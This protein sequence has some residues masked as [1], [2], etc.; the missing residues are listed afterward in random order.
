MCVSLPKNHAC[1]TCRSSSRESLLFD[2]ENLRRRITEDGAGFDDDGNEGN[3]RSV[4]LYDE[5]DD[6]QL[7]RYGDIDSDPYDDL[8]LA[9]R[10]ALVRKAVLARQEHG[11]S[12]I[13][14]GARPLKYLN[15]K[16]PLEAAV[17]VDP[18]CYG[19]S[20]A[21]VEQAAAHAEY[22]AAQAELLSPKEKFKAAAEKVIAAKKAGLSVEDREEQ[23]PPKID[24]LRTSYASTL[25]SVRETHR[26]S[27]RRY[28][29]RPRT[30]Y[31][32]ARAVSDS[33]SAAI[34]VL[35]PSNPSTRTSGGRGAGVNS[36]SQA[37]VF[38]QSSCRGPAE[39][40]LEP[41]R[42]PGHSQ[43]MSADSLACML[44][45]PVSLSAVPSQ[46]PA[47]APSQRTPV[48]PKTQLCLCA[49]RHPASAAV[50]MPTVPVVEA[51]LIGPDE[52]EVK[53]PPSPKPTALTATVTVCEPAQKDANLELIY[54]EGPGTLDKGHIAA[55]VPAPM[56]E[57]LRWALRPRSAPPKRRPDSATSVRPSTPHD[58]SD[59]S[60]PR[61]GAATVVGNASSLQRER[62]SHSARRPVSACARRPVSA[63]PAHRREQRHLKL[64]VAKQESALNSGSAGQAS[65]PVFLTQPKTTN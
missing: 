45:L 8:S 20:V 32:S 15:L 14:P 2:A 43:R 36:S 19:L 16:S 57:P 26:P 7:H 3:G 22:A 64:H 49:P 53:L 29:P 11:R 1:C 56:H 13:A 5:D 61:L 50:V 39:A 27:S 21:A 60:A 35:P 34:R 31:Q 25:T 40:E 62:S 18:S 9:E 28:V 24:D 59:L 48:G 51:E 55:T 44:V 12:R 4:C 38:V 46:R 23:A 54:N 6:S 58:P 47:T 41:K 33:N 65:S 37:R 63:A 10:R 52:P 42:G 30:P 17:L